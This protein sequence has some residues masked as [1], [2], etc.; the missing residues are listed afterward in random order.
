MRLCEVKKVEIELTQLHGAPDERLLQMFI[1]EKTHVLTFHHQ[2][3]LRG[4]MQSVLAA[5]KIIQAVEEAAHPTLKIDSVMLTA[6][7]D[8]ECAYDVEQKVMLAH[9]KV[10]VRYSPKG[11]PWVS[12]FYER[13]ADVKFQDLTAKPELIPDGYVNQ[14]LRQPHV[15]NLKGLM[16]WDID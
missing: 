3:L 14:A 16:T 5:Y 11:E 8:I 13:F 12:K 10:E 15:I 6:G 7:Y 2:N 4:M 1:E 9:M